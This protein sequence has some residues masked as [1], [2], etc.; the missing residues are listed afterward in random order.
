LNFIPWS[1]AWGVITAA[2][3][4]SE[5][6]AVF[7]L[8]YDVVTCEQGVL[9]D[10]SIDHVNRTVIDPADNAAVILG[11]WR[12]GV[13]TGTVR[14][15]LLRDGLAS[16]YSE[17]LQLTTLP[18]DERHLMSVCSRLLVGARWR[19]TSLPIRLAQSAI[20]HCVAAGLAWNYIL[21][22]PQMERFYTRLGYQ[23]AAASVDFPGVGSMSPLRL[24][25]D[26]AF[27]RHIG[28]ILI[29]DP[30]KRQRR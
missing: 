7:A 8:R 15:N 19:G 23:R 21:V 22:R 11:A 26:P 25:L 3:S 10:T 20:R 27:L 2:T 6:A 12:D 14:L 9:A 24:N 30:R 5:R 13:L 16:P 18:Q 4:P 29:L 28:S 1:G 17:F